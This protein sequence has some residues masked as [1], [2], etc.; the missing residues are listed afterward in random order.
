MRP[1]CSPEPWYHHQLPKHYHSRSYFPTHIGCCFLGCCF[2]SRWLLCTRF[3]SC[4]QLGSRLFGCWLLCSRR[5]SARFLYCWSNY[6]L[7]RWKLYC[8]YHCCSSVLSCWLYYP[9]HH[10]YISGHG[11]S[12]LRYRWQHDC[13]IEHNFSHFHR[14]HRSSSRFHH[15]YRH[16]VRS[17]CDSD[18]EPCTRNACACL[19]HYYWCLCNLLRHCNLT[20][21]HQRHCH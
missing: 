6:F 21:P 4:W 8:S 16:C 20:K 17:H 7:C 9:S 13:G 18:C 10:N 2:F 15:R 12:S 14:S 1:V 3:F 5:I 19:C 11:D